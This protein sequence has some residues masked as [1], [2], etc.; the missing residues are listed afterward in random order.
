MPP[1]L[2]ARERS[3]RPEF[4]QENVHAKLSRIAEVL[5]A[6]TA[7]RSMRYPA[8]NVLFAQGEAA[9]EIYVMVTGAVKLVRSEANTREITVG[10]C[11]RGSLVGVAPAMLDAPHPAR[12][13]T[14]VIS[15]IRPVA[16]A[17]FSERLSLERTLTDATVCILAGELIGQ[18]RRA[19]R[20]T[21]NVRHRLTLLLIDLAQS[22]GH[23]LPDG[24]IRIHL[25]L[26]QQEIAD[27]IVA[28]RESVN[29]AMA[30]LHR[31]GWISKVDGWLTISK[32][33]S[34]SNSR[35]R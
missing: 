2:L 14:M 20:Q 4:V 12:A 29:R 34:G 21:L 27:L 17:V 30:D 3:E 28:S 35:P 16:V 23:H 13:V 8:G 6:F 18:I 25:P 7:G 15:E 1:A 22:H 31:A 33:R 32:A 24:T 26:S 11:S 9:T 19:S 10:I 5:S